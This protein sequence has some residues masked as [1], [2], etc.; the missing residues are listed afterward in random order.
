MRVEKGFI[1]IE[2][3]DSG[4]GIPADMREVIFERFRQAD[5]PA[6]ARSAG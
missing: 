1:L 2:I 4:P 3:Q 5:D 6:R